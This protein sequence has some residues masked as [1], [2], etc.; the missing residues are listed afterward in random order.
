MLPYT[1][2]DIIRTV[3]HEVDLDRKPV[4]SFTHTFGDDSTPRSGRPGGGRGLF[5]SAL[6]RFSRRP[7]LTQA[8][9]RPLG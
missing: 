8:A 7:R 9:P 1:A 4:R 6:A 2:Y 3:N 5:S